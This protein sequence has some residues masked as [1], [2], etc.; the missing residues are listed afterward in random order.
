[1]RRRRS[2]NGKGDA[3]LKTD[4]RE[5]DVSNSRGM[6]KTSYVDLFFIN[7]HLILYDFD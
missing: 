1:M 7:F 4:E 2:L 6:Y 3:F 5:K